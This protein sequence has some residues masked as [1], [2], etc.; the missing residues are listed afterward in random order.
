MVLVDRE[1]EVYSDHRKL[2][3]TS[4]RNFGIACNRQKKSSPSDEVQLLQHACFAPF[5]QQAA[6]FY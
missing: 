6:D 2:S 1:E 3:T 5:A 4:C